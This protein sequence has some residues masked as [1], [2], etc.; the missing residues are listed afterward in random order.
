[1]DRLES[2]SVFVAVVAAGS[3]SAASRQLRMPLPTV[4]R[5]VAEIE[6]HLKAQ[7]LV[8]STRKLV[9][10][11]AGQA[12]VEDCKRIL[13]A[14]TAAERGASGEY[15]APQGELT[16]T[17]PIVFGRLH[18]VPVVTGFLRA[19]ARVDVR[20]LLADRALNLVEDRLDLAVRIGPL[21]DSRLVASRVG[22]IRRVVCASPEYLKERGT[23]RTPQDL[24][25]HDCV[26]FAGLADAGSWVF[27]DHETVRVH[28][29]LTASTAEA[30]ID[31]TVASLGLTCTLSYQIA[32]AV[33]AGRLAVV[34]RKF[35]PAPLPV[36]LI[37]VRESRITAKLRAFIDYAAPR[38]RARLSD[39][40]V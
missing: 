11:E 35:E 13:E 1:M 33:K 18:V 16:V 36:S 14:V 6:S 40:A 25:Q 34:L 15:N 19:Y 3:F 12:Y 9:L 7:L 37:Y 5:K 38:L 31:A 27:R 22:Q 4:S 28:S 39:A 21:P 2:M 26:T 10:T 32:D 20:L 29:R 30:A 23:P 24:L 17:A 8:R